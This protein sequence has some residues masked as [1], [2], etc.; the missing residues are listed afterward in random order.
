MATIIGWYKKRKGKAVRQNCTFTVYRSVD[1]GVEYQP[2]VCL[3][4]FNEVDEDA[5]E[6]LKVLLKASDAYK[7]ADQ[8]VEWAKE[9]ERD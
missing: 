5:K 4:F 7:L 8:L 9:T 3:E 1:I 2:R 6:V